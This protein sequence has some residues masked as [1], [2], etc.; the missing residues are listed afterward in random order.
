MLMDAAYVG[1]WSEYHEDYQW[2]PLNG[3]HRALGDA[4]AALDVLKHMAATPE[5]DMSP[6]RKEL[7]RDLNY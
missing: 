4:L 6:A 3:G 2:Q 7:E 1:Q 5:E